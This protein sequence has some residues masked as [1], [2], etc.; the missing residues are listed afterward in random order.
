MRNYLSER[1]QTVVL[2]GTFSD[3]SVVKCG[4]PRGTC[5]GP[6]LYDMVVLNEATMSMYVDDLTL[7]ITANTEKELKLD[8]NVELQLIVGFLLMLHLLTRSMRPGS[9]V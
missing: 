5:L 8:L 9:W 1:K 4:V 7:Y 6:L 2:N 3:I